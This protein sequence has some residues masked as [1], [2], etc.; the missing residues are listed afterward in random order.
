MEI[1]SVKERI[2]SFLP[3]IH[4][5]IKSI[6]VPVTNVNDV[7]LL[8]NF[9]DLKKDYCKCQIRIRFAILTDA[10][11]SSLKKVGFDSNEDKASL[12]KFWISLV[13]SKAQIEVDIEEQ[14]LFE[15]MI[16]KLSP[17]QSIN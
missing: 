7:N 9:L 8:Q 5:Q 3:E 4:H 6:H 17:Q 10:F 13:E 1:D 14:F 2:Y 12:M 16:E 15:E 11:Q